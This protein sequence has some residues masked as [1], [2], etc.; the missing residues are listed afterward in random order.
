MSRE[1]ALVYRNYTSGL[2]HVRMPQVQDHPGA[3]TASQRKDLGDE[4][5]VVSGQNL[6]P[7]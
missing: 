5:E 7:L 3:L 2:W 4:R 1:V 6:S